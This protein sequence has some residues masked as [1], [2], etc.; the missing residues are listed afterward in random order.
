M[1]LRQQELE[2]QVGE[3]SSQVAK[4]KAMKFDIL[5]A[6][7]EA[8]KKAIKKPHYLKQAIENLD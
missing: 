3:L 5:Y 7:K 6:C 1:N 2:V 8:V 4:L